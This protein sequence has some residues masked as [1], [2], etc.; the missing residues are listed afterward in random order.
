MRIYPIIP[1]FF[2][3]PLLIVAVALFV[4]CMVKK[5]LRV[6][7]NMRRISM[8]VLMCIILLRPVFIGGRSQSEINNLNLYF[9]VD[10]TYSMKAEDI[11]GKARYVK[12]A[13][14]IHEI[15]KAFPG[16]KYSVIVEDNAIYT[17]VPMSTS[18][19]FISSVWYEEL[20]DTNRDKSLISPKKPDYSIGTDLNLLL[21]HT[22]EMVN[23]YK[24]K[25]PGRKNII[26]FMS[27]GEDFGDGISRQETL[28][29]NLDGGAVFGYGSE[30]G[31]TIKD[32]GSYYGRI[33]YKG[34][35][36][37]IETEPCNETGF[38]Q[39]V[40]TKINEDNLKKIAS[41]LDINYYHRENGDVPSEVING[42]KKLEEFT[43]TSE[44]SDSFIDIY[45]V[46]SMI[47]LG[48]LL[49]DFREVLDNVIRERE[50]KHA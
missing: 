36:S 32:E 6:K 39:C 29:K 7:K 10:A 13:K 11:G 34:T 14:D 17:A 21:N 48:L 31:T 28:R 25:E 19:D 8:L 35:D 44:I 2:I 16:S 40:I 26:I 5:K 45:W 30:N 33:M 37:S 50:F 38:G 15:V 18:T 27:D 20:G 12:V 3:A 46:F 1:I 24:K 42:I 41:N 43:D 4:L 22:G 49:W 23:R 47:L 9:V